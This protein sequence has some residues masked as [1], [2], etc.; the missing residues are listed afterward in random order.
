MHW[1]LA[2]YVGKRP[3][4][5][6]PNDYPA[7]T[8]SPPVVDV[9]Q[10]MEAAKGAGATYVIVTAKHHDGFAMW[11]SAYTTYDVASS[12]NP[13]DVI[14]AVASTATKRGLAL[15]IYY[16]WYDR[17]QP[18]GDIVK[19]TDRSTKSAEYMRYVKAQLTELLT[20]YGPVAGLW[21]DIPPKDPLQLME[22][23]RHIAAVSPKT[24]FVP[25]LHGAT[26]HQDVR[27]YENTIDGAPACDNTVPAEF[28]M[29]V[30]QPGGDD[31]G[32]W[33]MK[34]TS[35]TVTTRDEVL[36]QFARVADAKATLVLNTS[37]SP[38]GRLPEGNLKLL[39]GVGARLG[40]PD[41]RYRFYDDSAGS[42]SC[43]TPRYSAGWTAGAFEGAFMGTRH[44]SDVSGSTMTF[45]FEGTG[46]ALL[47]QM[48]PGHGRA[49]IMIDGEAATTVDTYSPAPKEQAVLFDRT[50]L[51]SGTHTVTLRVRGDRNAS[52]SSAYIGLDAIR[53]LP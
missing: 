28:A 17:K 37:P 3:W 48:H 21:L 23:R 36:A 26:P 51:S 5:F 10:W 15:V 7:S 49:D 4:H 20:K 41:R 27:T 30:K 40:D 31:W 46:V 12:G 22:L 50:G 11:P 43:R 42:G 29:L 45:T 33:Q 16:S 32:W 13:T 19:Q 39:A 47:G 52:A 44:R 6:D 34:D 2:T 24:A 1:G 38:S 9:D 8:Y 35:S 53:V 25:N 18:G 14:A